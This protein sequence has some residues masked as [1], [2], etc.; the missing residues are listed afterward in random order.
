MNRSPWKNHLK[1]KPFP[2]HTTPC[3]I[4][5]IPSNP[6]RREFVSCP[7]PK[8]LHLPDFTEY[9]FLHIK[10]FALFFLVVISDCFCFIIMPLNLCLNADHLWV[11]NDWTKPKFLV[12]E[13]RKMKPTLKLKIVDQFWSLSSNFSF[14]P[15]R[16]FSNVDHQIL[17][18][19]SANF[20]SK[21]NSFCTSHHTCKNTKEIK[22]L[23]KTDWV[24]SIPRKGADYEVGR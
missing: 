4:C 18:L 3:L 23:W 16:L 5:D 17:L 22:Q 6:R 8:Y 24:V 19:K 12:K 1:P 20:C 21:I 11:L 7:S 15:P 10:L 2:C 9:A 14:V 13:M